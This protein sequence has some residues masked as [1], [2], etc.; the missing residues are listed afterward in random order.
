LWTNP[1]AE[2]EAIVGSSSSI[3]TD[4]VGPAYSPLILLGVS[5]PLSDTTVRCAM[6]TLTPSGGAPVPSTA[7]FDPAT[8]QIVLT[9]RAALDCF[10]NTRR[11]SPPRLR[12]APGTRWP[13]HPSGS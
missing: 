1:S 7:Q 2:A 13:S 3:F 12:I 4:T 9:P 6:V 5:E 10:S 11:R 8:N